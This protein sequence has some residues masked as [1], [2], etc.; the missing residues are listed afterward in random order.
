MRFI[1]NWFEDLKW[2]IASFLS[3]DTVVLDWPN[4]IHTICHNNKS[5]DSLKR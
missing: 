4:G 2:F 3:V 5:K 1:K